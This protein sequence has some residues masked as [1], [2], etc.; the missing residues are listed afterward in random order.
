[1]NTHRI[2]AFCVVVA[3][4]GCHSLTFNPSSG[5]EIRA[6]NSVLSPGDVIEFK[7]PNGEG[8]I[9]FVS[10]FVRR[11]EILGVSYNVNLIQRS[12]EFMHRKGIYNAGESFGSLGLRSSPRFVVDESAVEFSSD[13]EM[14]KFLKQGANYHKWVFDSHCGLLLGYLETPL[15]KQID[16]SLYKCYLNGKLLKAIPKKFSH[17]GYVRLQ[18]S[19]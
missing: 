17:P 6:R 16:V 4:A 19:D 11:Y 12:E 13:E 8:R 2:I 3:V 10:D 7:N 18:H 15:R 9:F 5:M 14:F 1:M